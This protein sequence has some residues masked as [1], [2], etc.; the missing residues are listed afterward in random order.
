MTFE[1]HTISHPMATQVGPQAG[2]NEGG[3]W[4]LPHTHAKGLVKEFYV[5]KAQSEAHAENEILA[6]TLYGHAGVFV[7]EVYYVDGYLYSQIIP[8]KQDM[9]ERIAN[10]DTVWLGYLREDFVLDAWLANWDVFGLTWDNII[11]KRI[12]DNEMPYK[13]DNGGALQYRAMGAPKG[14]AFGDTVP[15]LDI[16]RSGK[17][18]VIFGGEMTLNQELDGLGRLKVWLG[19]S[20]IKKFAGNAVLA[21][22]LIRRRDYI[23]KHY[24][25]KS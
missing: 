18:A 25:V 8:G 6:N 11:T 22:T 2:S 9:E 17:K 19:E 15:E 13:I 5:K 7:P 10:N 21:R 24:G 4:L 12:T 3:R 16:F 23:I 14:E 20:D 1:F